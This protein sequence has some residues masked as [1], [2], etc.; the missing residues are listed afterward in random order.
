MQLLHL[1]PIEFLLYYTPTFPRR[2]EENEIFIFIFFEKFL[3][4]Y[5][6]PIDNH[7]TM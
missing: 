2:K 6:I 5:K 7:V 3:K 4:N 1:H